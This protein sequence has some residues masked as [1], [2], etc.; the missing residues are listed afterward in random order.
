[1]LLPLMWR[2]PLEDQLGWDALA[3]LLA[4]VKQLYVDHP[5]LVY[6]KKDHVF[7]ALDAVAPENVRVVILGQDPYYNGSANG[8][9]FLAKGD[10]PASLANINREIRDWK[11]KSRGLRKAI[12]QDGVLLLNT[13]LTV[14]DAQPGVHL[15]MWA[16]FTQ[17]VINTLTRSIYAPE[18]VV[19]MLWGK[20]AQQ[21]A[22]TIATSSRSKKHLVLEAAHPSPQSAHSGFFGCRHFEKANI[23]LK[24][25]TGVAVNW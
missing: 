9:A 2:R 6:P 16:D 14:L 13:A 22:R 12:T 3:D 10:E 1:M 5:K 18:Y 24:E 11:P 8:F 17:A 21:Y 19:W 15:S 25:K 23:Y 20:Q 4:D 7:A